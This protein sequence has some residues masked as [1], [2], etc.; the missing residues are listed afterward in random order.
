GGRWDAT[1]V[2]DIP[3]LTIITPIS[4]DHTDYLGDTL[5]KIAFEK[6]GIMKPRVKCIIGRQSAE[7][8]ASLKACAIE[9]DTPIEVYGNDWNLSGNTFQNSACSIELK[10]ALAGAH[11]LENASLATAAILAIQQLK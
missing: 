8:L 1:N 5:T 2:V 11:Q 9:R 3:L 10:P 4:M 6:A 7:A